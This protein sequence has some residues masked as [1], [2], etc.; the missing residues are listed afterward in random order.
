MI[1]F[2][3]EEFYVWDDSKV[4][5]SMIASTWFS[6]RPSKVCMSAPCHV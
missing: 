3:F 4:F 6:E 1:N 2:V 5:L